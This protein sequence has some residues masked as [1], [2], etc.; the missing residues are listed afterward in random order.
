MDGWIRLLLIPLGR[1]LRDIFVHVQH[2]A[3][4]HLRLDAFV[5]L[6]LFDLVGSGSAHVPCVCLGF[7]AMPQVHTGF[8][9]VEQNHGG[10]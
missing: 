9:D 4:T 5:H 8:G 7:A 1:F 10:A 6:L 2:V 3:E